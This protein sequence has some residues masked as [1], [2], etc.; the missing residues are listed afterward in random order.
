M[1]EFTEKYKILKEIGAGTEGII[2]EALDL[3]NDR[4]VAVK[5]LNLFNENQ[6]EKVLKEI[7]LVQSLN[8]E[9]IIKYYE[10]LKHI[11]I[12]PFTSDEEIEIYIIM[13]LCDFTLDFLI[14]Q[15][16]QNLEIFDT[17][18]LKSLTIQICS[19]LKEIHNLNIIHR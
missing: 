10:Y 12:D 13:E 9:N 6:V 5:Q 8:H 4:K 16:R 11:N 1:T 2:Y 15:K 14:Q 7:E 17:L 19:A 3:K 18:L